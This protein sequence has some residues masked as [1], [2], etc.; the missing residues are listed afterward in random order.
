MGD[1]TGLPQVH[2]KKFKDF[3]RDNFSHSAVT[4]LVGRQKGI[5]PVKMLSDGL[6]VVMIWL[7]LC[8]SPPTNQ[9]P[10]LSFHKPCQSN[11]GKL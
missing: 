5:E 7:V 10:A 4:L 2:K 6:L 1:P 9:R 3:S 8:T 11:E